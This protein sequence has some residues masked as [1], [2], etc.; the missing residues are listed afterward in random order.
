[1]PRAAGGATDRRDPLD[2]VRIERGPVKCLDSAHREA[3]RQLDGLDAEP[4][5]REP[6]LRANVVVDRH[7]RET[8]AVERLGRVAWRC[9]LAVSEQPGDD[10]EIFLRIERRLAADPRLVLSDQAIIGARENDRVVSLRVEGP[11][12]PVGK[13]RSGQRYAA[14][15]L[16]VAEV[17]KLGGVRNHNSPAHV[18]AVGNQLGARNIRCVVRNEE[19]DDCGDLLR[20]AQ[21]AHRHT[22]LKPSGACLRIVHDANH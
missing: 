12:S 20:A 10:D 9:R 7:F 21:T 13:P 6:M 14:L 1:V 3:G 4:F 5:R 22:C 16:E 19:R 17:E 8:G 2:H 18:S 11:V 15:Q